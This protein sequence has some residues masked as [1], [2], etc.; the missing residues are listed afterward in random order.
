MVGPHAPRRLTPNPRG[1]CV[2]LSEVIEPKEGS[3]EP[4]AQPPALRR[5]D[6]S[7]RPSGYDPICAKR[8]AG[9]DVKGT[10]WIEA[11][12]GGGGGRGWTP[13]V[14]GNRPYAVRFGKDRSPRHS[15]RSTASA[16]NLHR[17]S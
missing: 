11:G 6:L 5:F 9:V 15:R 7:N 12:G 17:P 13:L 4:L 8:T 16:N 14:G 1:Q 10:L 2:S 3:L